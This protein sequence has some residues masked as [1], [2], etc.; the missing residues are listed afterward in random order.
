MASFK[1]IGKAYDLSCS[2]QPRNAEFKK[3]LNLGI[4]EAKIALYKL[5]TEKPWDAL[6]QR[7]QEIQQALALD[8]FNTLNG[9]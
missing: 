7:E 6:T 9:E 3:T 2:V 4:V 5:L 8:G 1:N